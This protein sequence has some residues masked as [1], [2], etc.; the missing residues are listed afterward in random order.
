MLR[1]RLVAQGRVQAFAR[2]LSEGHRSQVGGPHRG[3]HGPG[4][5][6]H[7]GSRGRTRHHPRWSARRCLQRGGA[8]RR[9]SSGGVTVSL[10][11]EPQN[12]RTDAR[13][14][15]PHPYPPPLNR[16]PVPLGRGLAHSLLL[17]ASPAPSAGTLPVAACPAR[18][19]V[20]CP[21]AGWSAAVARPGAG[22]SPSPA[23]SCRQPADLDGGRACASRPQATAQSHQGTWGPRV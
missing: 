10:R 1:A 20:P 23:D 18:P 3:P 19:A 12:V 13:A 6:G 4:L 7:Q 8:A 9:R 16:G 5:R 11:T 14:S 17:P 22:C 15:C 21:P 2:G